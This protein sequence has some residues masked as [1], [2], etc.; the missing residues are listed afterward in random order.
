MLLP[1]SVGGYEQQLAS[2]FDST[3][4]S[5]LSFIG[6]RSNYLISRS[7]RVA[8]EPS[9]DAAHRNYPFDISEQEIIVRHLFKEVR[10]RKLIF[11]IPDLRSN[12]IDDSQCL[13][14]PI[15]RRTTTS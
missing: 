7:P 10:N 13:S 6:G 4:D 8:C 14:S 3:N 15:H 9:A 2:P 11:A 1:Q 5:R 12:N